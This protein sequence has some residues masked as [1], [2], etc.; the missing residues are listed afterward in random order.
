MRRH[1]I[2]T[3][4]ALFTFFSAM[5]FPL[6]SET[7]VSHLEMND[8]ISLR[9]S[10]ESKTINGSSNLSWGPNSG[11][12]AFVE[13]S[14]FIIMSVNISNGANITDTVSFTMESD[15]G[16]DCFWNSTTI[17][18][19]QPSQLIIAPGELGWPKYDIHVPPVVNGSPLAFVRH[20]FQLTATSS[21][22]SANVSYNFTLE[23]DEWFQAAFDSPNSSMSLEPG[24]KERATL[25]LRNTGNSP[26]QLVARVVPLGPNNLPLPGFSPEQSYTHE[27]NISYQHDGWLVGLFN[28]HHLNGPSGNG[29]GANSQV[30]IDIEIQPPSITSGAMKVGVVAWSAYN[31]TE[32]VMI[33]I[34]SNISWERDGELLVND[35]CKGD[36]VLPNQSCNAVISIVNTGN[37]EDAYE[38]HVEATNWLRS[39]LSRHTT[40]LSKDETQEAATLT[41]TVEGMVPAFSHGYATITLKLI[42]GEILGSETIELRVAPLVNWELKSVESTTDSK[43][44]V[45]VAFTMRNLGNGDDGLQVSLHVDMNV[46]HGFIPPEQAEHGSVSGAP[47]YFE[48]DEIPPGVNF[49]FRAWMHIPRNTEANGTLTMTVEMQSTLKPDVTFFNETEA[50]YL[51][52]A[53]RPE[54][55]P[56]ESWWL[57][58]EIAVAEIWNEFNGLFFTILVTIIGGLGLFQAL[59]HRQRKDAEWKAKLAASEPPEPEKPEEWMTKFSDGAVAAPKAV[60]GAVLEAPK[61]AAKVFQDLFTAKSSPKSS[62]A[63]Q[64]SEELLDAANTVLTHHEKSKESDL[65]DELANELVAEKDAHPANELFPKVVAE[66]GRTVRKPK[67]TASKKQKSAR[68][69]GTG[70]GVVKPVKVGISTPDDVAKDSHTS[71][72]TEDSNGAEEFDLDL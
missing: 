53:F 40:V 35:N 23:I 60:V 69:K 44:N 33:V 15:T 58:V 25:T 55:L 34:D 21:I 52:E 56:K 50:V 68:K 62:E 37:F 26:A 3:S 29:I 17:P 43:D 24:L 46:E 38:I 2:L 72:S 31:P 63:N 10:K 1:A 67:R 12:N 51:A 5:L 48:I 4:L 30:T 57:D 66:S 6:F 9:D 39:E 47:R 11:L 42:S 32:T 18:C 70:K 22:D 7:N 65:I 8:E 16:W 64:P 49:T 45:T 13:P 20:E 61:I 27:Q 71:T 41:L 14:G 28:V 36:D 54:N 59:K 19:H